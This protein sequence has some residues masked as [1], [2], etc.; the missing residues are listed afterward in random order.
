MAN[1]DV[2]ASAWSRIAP[3][4]DRALELEPHE[5]DTWLA[6]LTT[7]H[8]EIASHVRAFLAEIAS[9]DERGFLFRPHASV[10][11]RDVSWTGT[12]IGAYTLDG[13]IGRGG[14]GEVWLAHRSDGRFEGR[15]AVKLLDAALVGQPA[16]QRFVHEGSLL[17]RLQHP[18][19][20]HLID[21]GITQ[22]GQP[23]LVL[24]YGEGSRSDQ[25]C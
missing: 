16:E 13:R 11:A 15:A 21:A 8:P 25:F 19:I 14:M 20:A 17:A 7:T 6:D 18:H 22:G 9:L 12:R 10:A 2:D 1:L 5:R 4:V 3:Y 23:D 24:E